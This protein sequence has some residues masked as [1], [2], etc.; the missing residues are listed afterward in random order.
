LTVTVTIPVLLIV[1][2][3]AT[4]LL[5]FS[6]RR[7]FT[8]TTLTASW[9][10]GLGAAGAGL[11]CATSA[12]FRLLPAGAADVAWYLCAVLALCPPIAV[13]GARRPGSHAWTW[14]VLLPLVAVL[15]WPAAAVV[16]TRGAVGPLELDA[17]PLVGVALVLVMG[18]GNYI[19][20]RFGFAACLYAVGQCLIVLPGTRLTATW[21]IAADHYRVAGALLW[22]LAASAAHLAARRHTLNVSPGIDRLWFD[23]RNT[24][25]IVWAH[26]LQERV[27]AEADREQWPARLTPDGLAWQ[28]QADEPARAQA[29]PRIE[30]TLRWLLRRFVDEPWID[31]RIVNPGPVRRD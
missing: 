24:F 17:P 10:W 23:F 29:L 21:T 14:F 22:L 27:N 16:G 4:V 9:R 5:V 26:R 1:L 11:A 30:H 20:T 6:A 8:E 19:G 12:A 2:T 18:C 13:L 7:W 31:A 28:P 25:G 15:G 3:A